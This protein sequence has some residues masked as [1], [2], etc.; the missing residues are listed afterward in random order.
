MDRREFLIGAA[1]AG[2]GTAALAVS[3]KVSANTCEANLYDLSLANSHFK[4]P[5]ATERDRD[6]AFATGSY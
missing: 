4:L 6:N 5:L 2:V 3:T 1:V